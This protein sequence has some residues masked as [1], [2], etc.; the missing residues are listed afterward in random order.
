MSEGMQAEQ[1][2]APRP[3]ELSQPTRESDLR[4]MLGGQTGSE[5][6]PGSEECRPLFTRYEL[7]Q[8]TPLGFAA[9][10]LSSAITAHRYWLSGLG[11]EGEVGVTLELDSSARF[12]D[13]DPAASPELVCVDAI[14]VG[15]TFV[16][17][18][19]DSA[20]ISAEVILYADARE[21]FA[22]EAS[23]DAAAQQGALAEA[24]AGADVIV[25]VESL[26]EGV[27]LWFYRNVDGTR[28]L[29]GRLVP[30]PSAT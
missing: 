10:R 12:I 11:W 16:I 13:R 6:G 23:L 3:A 2:P 14:L 27:R 30:L 26:G 28:E 1:A 8:V 24:A 9:A 22:G 17:S 18:A 19:G 21:H 29:I 15:A 4:L 25:A 20:P 7:A 5:N